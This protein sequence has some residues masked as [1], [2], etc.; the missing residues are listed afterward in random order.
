[1]FHSDHRRSPLGCGYTVA[2]SEGPC[3]RDRRRSGAHGQVSVPSRRRYP[4]D[5]SPRTE[6]VPF[7]GVIPMMPY[8][9]LLPPDGTGD[10]STR[11][12]RSTRPLLPIRQGVRMGSHKREAPGL[13]PPGA[14]S[15][16]R[17]TAGVIDRRP[18]TCTF[19]TERTPRLTTS[20]ALGSILPTG[21]A[22]RR[23][24]VSNG[25]NPAGR[26]L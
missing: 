15:D 7:T 22:D 3:Q 2:C 11:R 1:M 25:P 21:M 6:E 8:T 10:R 18:V 24:S 16:R 17:P 5:E 19:D 20:Y 4:T 12:T 9:G 26:R 14:S 13:R 23:P